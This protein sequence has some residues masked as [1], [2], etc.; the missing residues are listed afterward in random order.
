M[1]SGAGDGS[2]ADGERST[3]I[4]LGVLVCADVVIAGRA[5]SYFASGR[6]A[7]ARNLRVLVKNG[8]SAIGFETTHVIV[9]SL[10][11]VEVGGCFAAP[12]VSIDAF[13]PYENKQTGD[14]GR[15]REFCLICCAVSGVCGFSVA[16]LMNVMRWTPAT[17]SPE[18]GARKPRRTRDLRH[19]APHAPRK[20]ASASWRQAFQPCQKTIG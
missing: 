4:A 2:D 3:P 18:S 15:E 7:M 11:E 5:Q 8:D 1:G 6:R 9:R 20:G 16:C 13:K 12:R 10:E 14:D 19:R 17:R